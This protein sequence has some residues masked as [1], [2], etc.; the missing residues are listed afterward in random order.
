MRADLQNRIAPH[1]STVEKTVWAGE[2]QPETPSIDFKDVLLQS[3]QEVKEKRAKLDSGDLSSAKS[4][5][6]FIENLN[7]KSQADRVPK[8]DLN[9]D[10][11][12]K[13]FVTQLQNQDPLSPKDGAEMAAQLAQFNGL[14]QMLNVNQVLQRI[15]SQGKEAGSVEFVNY[16]GKEIKTDSGDVRLSEGKINETSLNLS[17]AANRVTLEV[18]DKLG[19]VVA[20][21]ELG[22]LEAGDHPLK[23]D[24]TDGKESKFSDGIY[25]L[26]VVAKGKGESSI[27]VTVTSTVQVTGVNL[28][29]PEQAFITE[30]GRLGVKDIK[31]VGLKHKE[32]QLASH[33]PIEP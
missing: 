19:K 21:R 12:L 7:K 15:E 33:A 2:A 8:S 5:T 14:E 26:Q 18:R 30:V 10:D 4:Y 31:E 23:W 17:Q 11:F 27:P 25:S 24:G 16:I 13:L 1:E 20:Q 22:G 9:K 6:E 3:N 28:R 29:Q 32:T